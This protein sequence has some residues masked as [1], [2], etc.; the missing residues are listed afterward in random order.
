MAEKL[1]LAESKKRVIIDRILDKYSRRE[2][3]TLAG[4]KDVRLLCQTIKDMVCSIRNPTVGF[5]SIEAIFER[6]ERRFSKESKKPHP[7]VGVFVGKSLK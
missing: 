3:H 4:A 6:L 1:E 5:Y 2:K 7:G